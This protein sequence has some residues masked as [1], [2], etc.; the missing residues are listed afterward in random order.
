VHSLI[1]G[2]T[3]PSQIAPDS[4]GSRAGEDWGLRPDAQV[5]GPESLVIWVIAWE[6]NG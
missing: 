2:Y 1:S 5:C 6:A 4:G 3:H